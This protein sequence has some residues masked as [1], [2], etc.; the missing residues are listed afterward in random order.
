MSDAANSVSTQTVTASDPAAEIEFPESGNPN[1]EIE[2]YATTDAEDVEFVT[3]SDETSM[4]TVPAGETN[5]P[6]GRWRL[7]S[8]GKP[9][10][11]F[12]DTDDDVEIEIFLFG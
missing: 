11:V 5:Y 8:E 10:H 3:A 12:A 7:H 2:I 9:S 1:A 6:V 4:I